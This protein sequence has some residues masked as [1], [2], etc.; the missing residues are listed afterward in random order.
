MS[1]NARPLRAAAASALVLSSFLSACAGRQ[2]T[3]LRM[4]ALPAPADCR[5]PVAPGG[6]LPAQ[7]IAWTRPSAERDRLDEWCEATGP[8]LVLPEPAVAVP[9]S[10]DLVVI[11]WNLDA[12]QADVAE[13]VKR[14]RAGAFTGG[15]PARHFVLLLQEAYRRSG[16]GS[17]AASAGSRAVPESPRN[18]IVHVARSLGLSLYYVPSMRSSTA[19][20]PAADRGNAILATG[21]LSDLTAIE[22]PF[23]RQRRVAVSAVVSGH[24]LD[25][26]TWRLRVASVHL[27]NLASVRRLWIGATGARVRQA[28]GLL[29]AL[30]LERPL[31]LGGDLNTW[32]GFSDPVYRLVAEA[33]PDA[34]A[35]RRPTFGP[36][37]RLDHLFTRLPRGWTALAAR[38]DDRLGSDHYPLLARVRMPPLGR[39]TDE[40][41]HRDTGSDIP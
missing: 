38:L 2:P 34:S 28:R 37:F 18:D 14:L 12:G 17:V 16:S 29:A 24:G 1:S 6:A 35:D 39:A 32:F 22:L 11:S 7:H 20:H 33:V 9:P 26:R 13:L 30:R 27:D 21:P 3:M 31:I 4:A 15:T 41:G 19:A 5:A 25:G 10:D 40:S 23:E 36:L 8:P